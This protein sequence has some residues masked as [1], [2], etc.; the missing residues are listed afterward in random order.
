M[1]HDVLDCIVVCHDS[2]TPSEQVSHE[3]LNKINCNIIGNNNKD[4]ITALR[5]V[6]AKKKVEDSDV[7]PEECVYDAAG[8]VVQ[9]YRSSLERE[10]TRKAKKKRMTKKSTSSPRTVSN[11]FDLLHIS[12]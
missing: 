8:L 5:E 7:K 12:H 4:I 11:P 10:K 2:K 1:A 6:M 3:W 9:D